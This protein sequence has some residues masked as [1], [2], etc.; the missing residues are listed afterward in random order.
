MV[1]KKKTNRNSNEKFNIIKINIHIVNVLISVSV[2]VW[3]MV[4]CYEG[5]A[6]I[7]CESRVGLPVSI[8]LYDR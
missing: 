8:Q 4:M 5:I 1:L 2:L 7:K 3:P 6:R